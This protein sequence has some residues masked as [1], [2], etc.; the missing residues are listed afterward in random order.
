MFA[1]LTITTLLPTS[2][3]AC[4]IAV[5]PLA[6]VTAQQAKPKKATKKAPA[7]EEAKKPRQVVATLT[8]KGA[9][10]EMSASDSLFAASDDSLLGLID[11][12]NQAAKDEKLSAMV[13]KI[14]GASMQTLDV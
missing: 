11:R 1:K 7:D 14:R 4:L 3:L 2:L 8:L 13:L 6:P 5:C 12:L 9:I 10:S